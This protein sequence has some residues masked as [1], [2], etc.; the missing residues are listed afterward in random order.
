MKYLYLLI[1]SMITLM[2][3]QHF[4]LIRSIFYDTFCVIILILIL[5]LFC[6]ITCNIELV[7]KY[8]SN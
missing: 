7:N 1:T 5:I 4:G 2:S 6:N 8:L 3:E